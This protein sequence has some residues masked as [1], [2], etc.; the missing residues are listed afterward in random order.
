MTQPSFNLK[1]TQTGAVPIITKLCQIAAIKETVNHIVSWKENIAKISPGLLI[2]MLVISILCGRRPLWKV[3]QFWAQQDLRLLFE[4]EVTLE[5][6]NDDAF[7]HVLDKLAEVKMEQI[8]NIV[9]LTLLRAHAID[10]CTIHFDTTS[11]AV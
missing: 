8:V 10:I 6:L 5:P 4:E 2:E 1:V 3:H 11:K 9:S 7:G